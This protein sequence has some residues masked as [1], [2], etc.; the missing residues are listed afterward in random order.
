MEIRQITSLL[1]ES[2]VLLDV[3]CANG[4]STIEYARANKA[5]MFGVD[6]AAEMIEDAEANL[7]DESI[8]I[9]DRVSFKVGDARCL[10]IADGEV[11]SL[12]AGEIES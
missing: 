12:G 4:A 2:G 9:R 6:Y 3:G 7:A 1:P 8:D 10:D 11:L 5:K